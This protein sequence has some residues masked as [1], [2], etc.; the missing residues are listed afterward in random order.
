MPYTGVPLEDEMRFARS[1]NS[2]VANLRSAFPHRLQ[3][4]CRWLKVCVQR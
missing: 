2:G 4:K 3:A 1:G